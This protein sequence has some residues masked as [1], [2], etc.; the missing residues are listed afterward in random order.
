M[1]TYPDRLPSKLQQ[2]QA[3]RAVQRRS[4][5]RALVAA[6]LAERARP[7]AQA[8][9]LMLCGLAVSLA[10][11]GCG[12]RPQTALTP[13]LTLSRYREALERDD[14][15]AAYALLGQAVQ[16]GLPYEQ[17]TQQW[18][19][20]KAER[21]AQAAQLRQVLGSGLARAS[22]PVEPKRSGAAGPVDPVKSLAP[23]AAPTLTVRAVVTL[24]Q[25]AQ[26]ILTPVP[27]AQFVAG[28]GCLWRILDPDLQAVRAQTPEAALRLLLAAAEQRNYSA[29]LRLLT[30]SER[31]S[32]EAELAERIERLRANLSRGQPSETTTETTTE[33][34]ADRARIQYDPRFFIDLRREPDG[35]RIADFN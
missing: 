4:A 16:Q 27:A 19:D 30:K 8:L 17:F 12:A 35:W 5:R 13:L 15:K 18:Q 6:R 7:L 3:G 22:A 2:I 26:L 1:C 34:T 29:L 31:Q 32:L 9:R 24:P 21:S 11:V 20:T 25:G 14:P 23:A 33:T 28:E 10:L